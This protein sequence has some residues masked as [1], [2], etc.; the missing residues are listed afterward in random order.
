MRGWFGGVWGSAERTWWRGEGRRRADDRACRNAVWESL[1]VVTLGELLWIPSF[2]FLRLCALLSSA[3]QRKRFV[4]CCSCRLKSTVSRTASRSALGQ[5]MRFSP[6]SNVRLTKSSSHLSLGCLE[7]EGRD[8]TEICVFLPLKNQFLE[9]G[10]APRMVVLSS[11][12]QTRQY[13]DPLAWRTVTVWAQNGGIQ[14]RGFRRGDE[15]EGSEFG[16]LFSF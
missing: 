3:C 10:L 12:S 7:E 1:F 14:S 8:R 6:D 15:R 11:A 2:L 4:L 5:S 16:G 13:S 9:A